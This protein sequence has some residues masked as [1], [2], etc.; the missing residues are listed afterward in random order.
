M[1]SQPVIERLKELQTEL[2]KVS[3]AV[4]H[5]DE[6]AKV[7]ETASDILKKIPDLLNDLKALEEKFRHELIKVHKDKVVALEKLLQVLL[8]ELEVKSNQLTLLIDETKKLGKS[9][10][11]YYSEIKKINF[12]E[13]LDKI[14][15]QIS[16]I[17]IGVGNLQ[18]AIQETQRRIETGFEATIQ[19]IKKEFEFANEN[20]LQT[21]INIIY[22]LTTHINTKS[23][24]F[25]QHLVIQDEKIKFVS[26]QNEK[27]KK[28]VKANRIIQIIGFAVIIIILIYVV[29][30][31]H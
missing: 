10:S 1:P 25:E 17:N 26:D 16:S 2:E 6:A 23:N 11:D 19:N 29:V 7:A 30:T 3:S 14:D 18:T 4:K 28:E 21:R 13:R 5:I 20:I 22:E 31:R 15:N 12:P 24:E 9:I 8:S 27:L